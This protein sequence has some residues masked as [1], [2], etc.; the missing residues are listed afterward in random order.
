MAESIVTAGERA[1]ELTRQLLAYSGKAM[2]QMQPWIW[3]RLR[4][5]EGLIRASLPRKVRLFR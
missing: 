3:P 2:F 4:E 1:A 5:T